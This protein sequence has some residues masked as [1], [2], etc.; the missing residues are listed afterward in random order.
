M[1]LLVLKRASPCASLAN[2]VCVRLLAEQSSRSY[3]A[4]INSFVVNCSG[5]FLKKKLVF[6]GN[7]RAAKRARQYEVLRK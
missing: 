6:V 1:S 3:T 5:A 4:L 2:Y 7:A